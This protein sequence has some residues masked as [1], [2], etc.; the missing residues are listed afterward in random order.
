[1][2]DFKGDIKWTDL[3]KY[4]WKPVATSRI[5]LEGNKT[6]RTSNDNDDANALH[7]LNVIQ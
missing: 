2:Y 3:K 7:L 6:I 4:E 5:E 1:M